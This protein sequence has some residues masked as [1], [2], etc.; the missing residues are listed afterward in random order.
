MSS[1]TSSS[2]KPYP[3]ILLAIALGMAA[4]L[5]VVRYFTHANGA[6]A[7]TILDRV[8]E[9]RAA[10]PKIVAGAD[11]A[12]TRDGAEVL[13]VVVAFRLPGLIEVARA[14]GRAP[15]RFPYIPGL[16]SFRE[17]PALLA[18]FRKLPVTPDVV[19]F[20]GAGFAHPR[21]FG[22]ACHV[23]LWLDLPTVGCAKSRLIGEAEEP[24]PRRGSYRTIRVKGEPI[25]RVVRSRD[26]TK[27]LWI[28]PGHLCDIPGAMRLVL[29]CGG[30][31]RLPE[32]T[33]IADREVTALRG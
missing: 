25:G 21:R 29:R 17:A 20:D 27:P 12:F 7:E 14:E 24:G 3:R 11:C 19:L 22:L 31:Y 2:R 33:R 30:G 28:S 6:S 32:P 18:A 15:V 4:S 9:A 5:G 26:D 8:M 10:L 1:S 23:G 16:L 13:A